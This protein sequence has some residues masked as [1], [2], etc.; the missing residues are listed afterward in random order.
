MLIFFDL[1]TAHEQLLP[2]SFTRPLA[3]LRVGILTLREKWEKHLGIFSSGFLTAS[4]LQEMYP[5]LPQPNGYLYLNG[6]VSPLPDLVEA[7]RQLPAEH[8]LVDADQ[9]V[10]ALRT[11]RKF[12]DPMEVSDYAF[13]ESNLQFFEAR[14]NK[15][16]RPSDIFLTNREEL[17]ADF[18]LLTAGRKSA[19][20]N[21]P[22]TAVYGAGQVFLEEGARVR[23]ATLNAESGPIYIGKNAEVQEGCHV[24]GA[25]A[26]ND[27]AT[28]NM[29]AKIKG[30]TTI[31]P[32]CKVG[33]EVSNSVLMGYSNKSHDG[34][35]GNS[36]LGEWCNLGAD[37]NVSNLK[38]NYSRIKVWDYGSQDFQQTE[39]IFHGLVMGDHAKC[40]INTMFNTGTLVGVGANVFGGGFPPKFVPSFS[41]GGSIGLKTFELDKFFEMANRMMQRRNKVLTADHRRM[42]TA[43]FESTAK[44]RG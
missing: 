8:G 3:E 28:L 33:G 11:T 42:L 25:F 23:A 34:F 22:H 4:W 26:L 7:V 6:S 2:L 39:L 21:D 19:P 24:R 15:L 20:I 30:D 43:V 40:G 18:Q 16:E 14:Y 1:P 41:W 9:S 35:L 13:E 10:L 27:H 36:V 37:T 29:G 17:I 12:T 31:G 44:Y 38:N 32:F 5:F